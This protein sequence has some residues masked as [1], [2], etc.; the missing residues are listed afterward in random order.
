MVLFFP[1]LFPPVPFLLFFFFASRTALSAAAG[2]LRLPFR[3][4][5]S[6]PDRPPNPLFVLCPYFSC[7]LFLRPPFF[8]FPLFSPAFSLSFSFPPRDSICSMLFAFSLLVFP[9]PRSDFSRVCVGSDVR[10]GESCPPRHLVPSSQAPPPPPP[11]FSF[12]MALRHHD[13]GP[14]LL[15]GACEREGWGE[16]QTARMSSAS[17]SLSVSLSLW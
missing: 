17:L 11:S 8:F 2:A 7:F 5:P 14:T 10:R 9:P 13:V 16:R 1:P 12:S 15:P 4:A 3:C 6:C